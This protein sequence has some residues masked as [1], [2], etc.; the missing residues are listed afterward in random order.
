M[1]ATSERNAATLGPHFPS[2]MSTTQSPPKKQPQTLTISTLVRGMSRFTIRAHVD[3]VHRLFTF[4][5]INGPGRLFR[6]EVSDE[7]GMFFT[8]VFLKHSYL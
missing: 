2:R 6:V 8:S 3:F 4:T 5:T 1:N 7:S